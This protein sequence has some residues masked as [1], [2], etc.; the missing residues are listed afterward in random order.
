MPWAKLE[1]RATYNLATSGVAH[2]KLRDLPVRIEDLEINGPTFYGYGPLNEALARR[3]GVPVDHLVV[4]TRNFHGELPGAG[5][6]A[7]ERRRSAGRT[8]D[9]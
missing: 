6:R 9:L 8:S 1:S 7:E 3:C 4:A 5:R 2:W